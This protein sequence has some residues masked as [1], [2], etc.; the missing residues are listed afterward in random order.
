MILNWQK[1]QQVF[2][3]LDSLQKCYNVKNVLLYNLKLLKN[4]F[5]MKHRGWTVMTQHFTVSV[6]ASLFLCLV[7]LL[8]TLSGFPAK[9]LLYQA[10]DLTRQVLSCLLVSPVVMDFFNECLSFSRFRTLLSQL[11]GLSLDQMFCHWLWFLKVSDPSLQAWPTLPKIWAH[12]GFRA[13]Y[14]PL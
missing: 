14:S 5:L 8:V 4:I 9:D 10:A 1:D 11:L 13:W 7:S 2:L 6:K 3:C 12:F